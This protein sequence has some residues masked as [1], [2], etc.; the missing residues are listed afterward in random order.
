MDPA[1]LTFCSRRQAL[2][3]LSQASGHLQG[4]ELV[5]LIV[6]PE[7]SGTARRFSLAM[8]TPDAALTRR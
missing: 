3:C 7:A 5:G 1:A 4:A 2:G 8:G 6:V